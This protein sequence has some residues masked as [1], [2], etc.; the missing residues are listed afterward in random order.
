ME[1]RGGVMKKK[2]VIAIVVI[3]SLVNLFQLSWNQYAYKLFQDAV[4]TEEVA[5]EVGKA[6][7]AGAYGEGI[8]ELA[9]FE[10]NE[11]SDKAW[12]VYGNLGK[13]LGSWPVTI[14]RKNDGKILKLYLT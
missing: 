12:I 5:I 6:V 2:R 8:L 14:I 4:P 11:Y 1:V 10:V 9:T 7:L 3:L 13:G